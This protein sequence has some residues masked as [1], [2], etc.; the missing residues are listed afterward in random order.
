MAA[1]QYDLTVEQGAT[2]R[3]SL[4]WVHP[5][6]GSPAEPGDA[7]DMTGATARM[8]VRLR[9]GAPVML[10]ATT[11]NGRLAIEGNRIDI[12]LSDEDTDS[13]ERSGVYDLEVEIPSGPMA[14]V[15]RLIQGK[16]VVSPNV[17][18]DLP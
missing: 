9:V 8:Q 16:V 12:L 5:A 3:R 4:S 18:R 2:F 10:E 14:G 13:L 11:E 7:V 15:H 6:P 17:T 1:A